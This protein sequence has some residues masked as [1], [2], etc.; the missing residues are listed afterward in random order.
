MAK[1]DKGQ[2]GNPNG[3]PKGAVNKRTQQWEI[4]AEYCVNGGLERFQ[5]EL[6]SLKGKAYVDAF[7]NLLEFHKPKL[8]RAE[9][10]HEGDTTTTIKVI[11]GDTD[12]AK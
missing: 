3:K 11:R 5:K 1:F 12:S 7:A 4:F 6:E 8:S 9:V 2:S 10:R